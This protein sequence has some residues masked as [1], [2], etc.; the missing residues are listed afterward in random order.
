[1]I[2]PGAGPSEQLPLFPLGTVLTP[3]MSLSLHIFEPRYR[4]LVADLLN[5]RDPR[6]PE[7]GVVALRGGSEVG[8]LQDVHQVGT[9]ARVTDVLPLPDGR[10]NLSAVGER[11]FVIEQLDTAAQ[12]YLM[13]TVRWLAEPDGELST[14]LVLRTRAAL[15]RH[16]QALAQLNVGYL[17]PTGPAASN[18]GEPDRT[19]V[20]SSKLDRAEVDTAA[21]RELS[22]LAAR[23]PWLPLLDRQ[24]LLACPDT[25]ARLHAART[26]LR[27]EAELVSQLRA[28]PITPAAL[29]D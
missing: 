24:E 28:V 5:D 27:R 22:Y 23:Q 21:A 16:Q 20:D 10:C 26:V 1:M 11:R 13:G 9:T 12:P 2:T 15:R 17:E 18:T 14:T 7:F 29:A 6:A 3:G 25:A 8:E 4:Q 19:P